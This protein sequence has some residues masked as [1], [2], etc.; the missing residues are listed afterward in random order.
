M[1]RLESTIQMGYYEIDPKHY[2]PIADMVIS[3]KGIVLDPCAGEGNFMAYLQQQGYTVHANELDV[4]RAKLCQ[5]RFKHALQ[6]DIRTLQV[7]RRSVPW[8]WLNPPYSNDG[9]TRIEFEMLQ[10][11]T[12]WVAHSGVLMYV[13]YKHHITFDMAR[14]LCA[15]YR[16]L[17]IYDLG[18]HLEYQQVLITGTYS[19]HNS[20]QYILDEAA[21]F[22]E[23][24]PIPLEKGKYS[25][26]LPTT[27]MAILPHFRQLKTNTESLIQATLEQGVHRTTAYK[28]LVKPKV[29]VPPKL[30]TLIPIKPEHATIAI[31]ELINQGNITIETDEY[32]TLLLRASVRMEKQVEVIENDMQGE[33]IITYVKPVTTLSWVSLKTGEVKRMKEDSE[34]NEFV[35]QY[36]D[37]IFDIISQKTAP[38]YQFDF[39]GHAEEIAK[40]QIN[41]NYLYPAQAH[42]V[43]AFQQG[44]EKHRRMMLI[45]EQGTGKTVMGLSMM[46][47]KWGQ[48]PLADRQKQFMMV[49]CPSHLRPNWEREAEHVLGED[50]LVRVLDTSDSDRAFQILLDFVHEANPN[51]VPKIIIVNTN[52]TK[53][54]SPIQMATVQMKYL[55][56][57]DIADRKRKTESHMHMAK[58][59]AMRDPKIHVWSAFPKLAQR[60]HSVSKNLHFCPSCRSQ[61][62]SKTVERLEK[63]TPLYC[64]DCGTP[65]WQYSHRVQDGSDTRTHLRYVD[66]HLQV[67]EA[68]RKFDRETPVE[69]GKPIPATN[70]PARIDLA[71]Y[72]KLQHPDK[73]FFL[74]W[75]EAQD[76][77]NIFSENGVSLSRLGNIA[78]YMVMGTGTPLNGKAS[79]SFNYA[80][81]LS[82]EIRKQYNWGNSPRAKRKERGGERQKQVHGD[83]SPKKTALEQYVA[84]FGVL[85][86]VKRTGQRESA[87]TYNKILIERPPSEAP[88]ISARLVSMLMPYMVFI[89]KRNIRADMPP[90]KHIEIGVPMPPI[91]KS[92]L[93]SNDDVFSFPPGM[94]G[95]IESA[96]GHAINDRALDPAKRWFMQYYGQDMPYMPH[97]IEYAK[98][99]HIGTIQPLEG[100]AILPKEQ[101]L[102]DIVADE[103]ADETNIVVIGVV[104]SAERDVRGRLVNLIEKAGYKTYRIDDT[105]KTRIEK[106]EQAIKNGARVIITNHKKVEVGVNLIWKHLNIKTSAMIHYQI[107]DNAFTHTQYNDRHSRINSWA[108][109][110]RV[111]YLFYE[112]SLAETAFKLQVEKQRQIA[113]FMGK[114]QD[115]QLVPVNALA[116]GGDSIEDLLLRAMRGKLEIKS[117]AVARIVA[118]ILNQDLWEQN[119]EM[120]AQYRNG[121]PQTVHV[122][123]P[124]KPTKKATDWR[125]LAI[126]T[127]QT[128]IFDLFAT[129]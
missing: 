13:I 39:A 103:L 20:E 90:T 34:I 45:G 65:L 55:S 75:D 83:P 11:A 107:T 24:Q 17:K 116:D 77:Q 54:G 9:G 51:G 49:V 37:Q 40:I 115:G 71:N 53:L 64:E 18:G 66:G 28:L 3:Q 73:L 41:G 89:E 61:L 50:R 43:A 97:R 88:G 4:E 101:A 19:Q 32:G 1:A 113:F 25:L 2:Q 33:D 79:S 10:R 109:E 5:A 58:N 122:P 114:T 63:R 124:P 127:H 42:I 8:L 108:D 6:G 16:S 85:K 80:Y 125:N 56:K 100:L 22:M 111:Y 48:L 60:L 47:V 84:A 68:T 76:G 74:F 15:N 44:L 93:S 26:T 105:P 123:T 72:I 102:L 21:K 78:R 96:E 92:Y 119:A 94:K 95:M 46:K 12:E 82:P 14:F 81:L 118:P 30:E 62:D 129:A 117:T 59:V 35:A 67:Y 98:K 86:Q 91:L 126:E 52:A 57:H 27:S 36:F 38:I 110:C 128:T 120:L 121:T 23:L 99:H 69:L 87:M 7:S 29:Y 104:T 112:K 106:I 31:I 70:R